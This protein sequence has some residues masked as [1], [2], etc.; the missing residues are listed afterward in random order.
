MENWK[1]CNFYDKEEGWC[2]LNSNW[3]SPMPE[4]VCCDGKCANYTAKESKISLNVFKKAVADMLERI[5]QDNVEIH[6]SSIEEGDLKTYVE[7]MLERLE[8]A[9]R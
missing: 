5:H 3:S 1:T 7:W 8:G 2:K 9:D 4:I 6:T